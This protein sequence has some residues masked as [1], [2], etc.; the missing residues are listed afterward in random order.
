MIDIELPYDKQKI[1][2][3]VPETNFAGK[4][5]SQAA[6]YENPVSEEETV[7]QSLDHP[8]GSPS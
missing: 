3:H 1:T 5:V 8:I 2:A 4:L 7:E 6:T